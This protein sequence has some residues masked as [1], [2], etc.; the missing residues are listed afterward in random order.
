MSAEE[1]PTTFPV[2]FPFIVLSVLF[3]YLLYLTFLR[4]ILLFMY[5]ICIYLYIGFV[6][7]KKHSYLY[8]YIYISVHIISVIERFGLY[9]EYMYATLII[10]YL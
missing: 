3:V 8:Y 7:K 9:C 2:F 1:S 6:E 5:R 10:L 4:A